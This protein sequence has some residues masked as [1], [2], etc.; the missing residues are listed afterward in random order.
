M[1]HLI[2]GALLAPFGVVSCLVSAQPFYASA[3]I[4]PSDEAVQCGT[5]VEARRSPGSGMDTVPRVYIWGLLSGITVASPTLHTLTP[6]AGTA[7]PAWLDSYCARTPMGRIDQGA[8]V[9]VSELADAQGI[10]WP[11]RPGNRP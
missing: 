8:L 9:L 7:I 3:G 10:R 6:P 5:W 4:I 11:A 1:N 2:C